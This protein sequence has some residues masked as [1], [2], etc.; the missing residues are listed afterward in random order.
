MH[1]RLAAIRAEFE[2]MGYELIVQESTRGT[3]RGGWLARYRASSDPAAPDGLARGN[4]ELEA[5]EVALQRLRSGRHGS[6]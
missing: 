6:R 2:R 4:T 5:A 1:D 3:T